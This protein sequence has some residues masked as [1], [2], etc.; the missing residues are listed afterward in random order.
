MIVPFITKVGKQRRSCFGGISNVIWVMAVA[1]T[2]FGQIVT[3]F[4]SLTDETVVS[5]ATNSRAAGGRQVFSRQGAGG[6]GPVD[7]AACCRDR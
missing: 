1:L 4:V 6:A 7:A 2:K 3:Q 5:C